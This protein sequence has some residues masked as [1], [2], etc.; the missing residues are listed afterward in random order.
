LF[1]VFTGTANTIVISSLGPITKTAQGTSS[2]GAAGI[3]A[4]LTDKM[5]QTPPVSSTQY[6]AYLSK[7]LGLGVVKPVYAQG[8]GWNV[9]QPVLEIWKTVR[10]LAYLFFIVFFV[11]IGFMIMFRKKIDPQTAASIQNSLPRIVTALILITFSY[12]LSGLLIDTIYLANA[13]LETIFVKVFVAGGQP[14]W[15]PQL[16]ITDLISQ[17]TLGGKDIVGA[18][19]DALKQIFVLF[20][21]NFSSI[22][23]LIMAFV[24]LSAIFRIF[25]TLLTRY[26][27]LFIY[28]IFAPIA[29]LWGALPGQGDTVPKFFLG[30]LSAA[31]TFPTIL[32]LTNLALYFAT[33]G[34]QAGF[35]PIA[36]FAP[37]VVGQNPD[38]QQ[39]LGSFVA[40]GILITTSRVPEII[41]EALKVR[42]LTAAAT[43]TE[44]TGALRRI[45]IIGGFA[46]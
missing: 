7:N 34:E 1:N 31:F 19:L 42:S 38:V 15:Q 30:F 3:L 24:I 13:L 40:L 35:Q 39:A 32:F 16:F 4:K 22:F 25:F 44:L 28:T 9:L 43:G 18:L 45:P 37:S 27:M 17:F 36:P 33:L 29:F 23:S 11:A 8:R 46:G 20:Q 26:V 21:G 10:N 12:A 41:E 2:N 6:L 14:T 5:L